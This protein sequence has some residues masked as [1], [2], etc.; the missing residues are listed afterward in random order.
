RS[1][2]ARRD[3]EREEGGL[4]QQVVPLEGEEVL[5]DAHE[6]EIERPQRQEAP[7]RR[8]V[9]DEAEA[10]DRPS[11]PELDERA[12]ARVEPEERRDGEDP[13]GP[14]GVEV[15]GG[16]QQAV[17]PEEQSDL[18]EQREEGGEGDDAEPAEEDIAHA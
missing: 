6:R 16:R 11:D 7:A 9:Q 17:A 15:R 5:A 4:E 18:D 12:I 3:E 1:Q 8:D 14:D 2:P 13:V 10:Q